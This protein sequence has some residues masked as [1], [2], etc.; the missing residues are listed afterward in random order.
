MTTPQNATVAAYIDFE[1]LIISARNQ[2]LKVDFRQLRI[3]LEQY[4]HLLT[5]CAYADW[6]IHNGFVRPLSTNGIQPIYVPAFARERGNGKPPK[7]SVDI[8]L[9]IDVMMTLFQP[10]YIQAY[11]LISGDRD[12]LPLIEALR[13]HGRQVVIIGVN[14]STSN[15]L[16]RFADKYV[17]YRQF[18]EETAHRA[19]KHLVSEALSN[20]KN[21]ITLSMLKQGLIDWF[22]QFEET[23]YKGPDGRPCEKFL[24]F[25]R[26]VEQRGTI[27]LVL[28]G[29]QPKVTLP[30]R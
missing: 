29:T 17:P 10:W 21:A 5:A 24:D 13:W 26:A 4:G 12:F 20:G 6:S 3:G 11:I 22:G 16:Q 30:D 18:I 23:G 27:K 9:C 1:N 2:K 25:A 19:V 7:N 8:Q 15:T 14:E 28:N